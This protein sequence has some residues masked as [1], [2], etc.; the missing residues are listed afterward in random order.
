LNLRDILFPRSRRQRVLRNR[1]AAGVFVILFFLV[2]LVWLGQRLGPD[3]V[4]DDDVESVQLEPPEVSVARAEIEKLVEDFDT[5][6][7]ETG[8][9]ADEDSLALLQQAV[10]K[11]A[12]IISTRGTAAT[13]E[14]NNRLD[15]L[16]ER[17]GTYLAASLFEESRDAESASRVAAAEGKP[18]LALDQLKRALDLQAEI[19]R[20]HPG[21][22]QASPSRARMLERDVERL[23][24]EPLT[25]NA[26]VAI[27]EAG[28]R[29][30]V[31]DFDG[32]RRDLLAAQDALRTIADTHPALA[33]DQTSMRERVDFLLMEVDAAQRRQVVE[34]LTSRAHLAAT[35][36]DLSKSASLFVEAIAQQRAINT[37][38]PGT[39]AASP[40]ALETLERDRQT[41]LSGPLAA[42][43][44]A[45][46]AELDVALPA[47]RELAAGE[48]IVAASALLSDLETQFPRSSHLDPAV[49][50]RVRFLATQREDLGALQDAVM[51]RLQPIPGQPA[52][53]MLDREVS[54]LLY[55]RLTGSN[56][57]TR[58]G[59]LLPVEGVTLDEAQEF[60]RRLS[61]VLGREVR[62][63]GRAEF[64]AAVQPVDP[65][66]VRQGCWHGASV[67]D[68]EPRPVGSSPPNARGFYDLLGNGSDW[69]LPD[70]PGGDALVA[71]GSVRDNPIAL[72]QVPVES[73]PAVERIRYNGFRVMVKTSD[74]P[75]E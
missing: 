72:A 8:F 51:E 75:A 13:L 61:W 45:R 73:R 31:G 3:T 67:P 11:A 64:E 40:G 43:L 69:L 16:R 12:W 47:R 35:E 28:R 66:H 54:Q 65:M 41:T 22:R 5:R 44:R 15:D 30:S 4:S 18:E 46:L 27:E 25:Q 52:W 42:Q 14:D 57:S 70:T 9:E 58:R 60:A 29:M 23:E 59:D 53:A 48:A 38:Y 24:A 68:R 17:L 49:M 63:P 56:P 74:A 32:A 6:S 39:S 50:L 19:N 20:D 71:G 2:V 33:R 55:S 62:L 37:S 34:E 1:W 26:S 21:A 7:A 10:D 36:G